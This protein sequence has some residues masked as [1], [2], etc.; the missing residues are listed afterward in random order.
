MTSKFRPLFFAAAASVALLYPSTAQAFDIVKI[1]FGFMGQV[2]GNFLDKPDDQ[3]IQG[4][5]ATPEYPGFAGLMSGMGGFID[6]RFIDYVGVELDVFSS[7]HK[8][9]ADFTVTNTGTGVSTAHDVEIRNSALHIPLLLK[10]ALPGEIVTP[11]M[12]VGP[13][14][15]LPGDSEISVTPAMAG[16]GAN[17]GVVPDIESYT[18][19]T[20]GFGMEFNLPIPTDILQV[21]IPLTLR[22]SVDPGSP[23]TREERSSIYDIKTDANGRVT[24]YTEDYETRWKFQALATL[25]AS[26]HF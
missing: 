19:V 26:V 22:G 3:T 25:G 13:E 18:L 1:G 12:F 20:F 10:G 21:R 6:I 11:T 17:F 24:A 15:V 5:M 9:S 23:N 14:F 2:G 16:G 7:S 8:G 4:Q